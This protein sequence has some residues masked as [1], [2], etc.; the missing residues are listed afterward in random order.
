M[1]AGLPSAKQQRVEDA[2]AR[3]SVGEVLGDGLG[4][5]VVGRS[6]VDLEVGDTYIYIYLYL[7]MYIYIYIDRYAHDLW[8]R[9][10]RLPKRL[11]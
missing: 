10:L 5:G 6:V 4:G 7:Y 1:L 11:T 2:R 3:C 8:I 9:E